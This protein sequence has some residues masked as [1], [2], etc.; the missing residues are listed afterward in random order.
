MWKFKFIKTAFISA[1]LLQGS[2]AL[3]NSR[4][5]IQLQNPDELHAAITIE[6][7]L[8]GVSV[9]EDYTFVFSGDSSDMVEL[10]FDLDGKTRDEKFGLLTEQKRIP[11][12]NAKFPGKWRGIFTVGERLVA[13]DASMLQLLV[14]NEITFKTILSSTVPTDLLRPAAD[15]GGEPTKL[16]IEVERNKFKAASRKVF[17][18]KYTGIA[19]IPRSWEKGTGINFAVASKV[20]GYPLMLLNCSSDAP[21]TCMMTRHCF[22]EGGPKIAA[23]HVA[24]VGVMAEAKEILI[25]NNKLNQIDVYKFNSCFDV[26]WQRSIKLPARLPKM[27]NFSIDDHQR[28]WVVTPIP[29]STTDSNLFYWEKEAWF[30]GQK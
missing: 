23:E 24:G 26:V 18:L 14:L 11:L 19:E 12:L 13:W 2:I 21:G 1:I 15:R 16:E 9:S 28:L 3:A 29:D 4:L 22:L 10:T 7:G 25:G 5:P 27:S 20:P 8:S 17:G 6:R 30:K